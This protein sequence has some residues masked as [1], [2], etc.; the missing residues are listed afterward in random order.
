MESWLWLAAYVVGFGV[1]Q[2][3]LYRHFSRKTPTAR[4]T[5]GRP[6]HGGGGR[7]TAPEDAETVPCQHCGSINEVHPM[8]RYCRFCADTLR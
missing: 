8:V 2:L 1:L 7:L 3:L 5:E 6:D 4:S